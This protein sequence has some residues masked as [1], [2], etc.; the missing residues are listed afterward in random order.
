MILK[1]QSCTRHE[2]VDV[3]IGWRWRRLAIRRPG[4]EQIEM[5]EQFLDRCSTR[6]KGNDENSNKQRQRY[7]LPHCIP[8]LPIA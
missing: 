6:P 1:D 5:S 7:D 3:W 4:S 2:N 8:T